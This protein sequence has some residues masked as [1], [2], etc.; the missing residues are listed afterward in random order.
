M[1]AVAWCWKISCGVRVTTSSCRRGWEPRAWPD[2]AAVDRPRRPPSP[3]VVAAR[4]A[5]PG[6]PQR[7]R[8]DRRQR[9]AAAVRVQRL[10]RGI[11]ALCGLLQQPLAARGVSCA[12][13]RWA[14]PPAG[15]A[16]LTVVDTTV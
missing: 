12:D 3:V 6:S 10:T 8:G 5:G 1:S 2:G 9:G 7:R 13:A 11:E 16:A 4:T 14:G 15:P